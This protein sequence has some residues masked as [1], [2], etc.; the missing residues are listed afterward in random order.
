MVAPP[1]TMLCPSVR[2]LSPSVCNVC[3]VAKWIRLA[4]KMT[5]ETYRERPMENRMVT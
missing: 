5:E 1:L 2:R 4:E 3:I